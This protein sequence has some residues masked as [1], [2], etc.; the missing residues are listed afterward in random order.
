[1]Q[2]V[3]NDSARP[4]RVLNKKSSA[5]DWLRARISGAGLA[6]RLSETHRPAAEHW[7]FVLIFALDREAVDGEVG[8][9]AVTFFFS[10]V[11]GRLDL[12]WGDLQGPPS[13]LRDAEE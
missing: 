8:C 9:P 7:R 11:S 10:P 3:R 1:M 6:V 13:T 2:S 12:I 5:K 4:A